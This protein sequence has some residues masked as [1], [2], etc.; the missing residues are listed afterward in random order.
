MSYSKQKP[1]Y[2]SNRGKDLQL[3]NVLHGAHDL[4]CGCN[5]PGEHLI[6]LLSTVQRPKNFSPEEK[7]QIKECLGIGEDHTTVEDTGFDQ[8]DLE[9]LFQEDDEEDTG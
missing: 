8:G 6:W 4:T 7:D 3:I 2:Y 9:K 5:T 1:S